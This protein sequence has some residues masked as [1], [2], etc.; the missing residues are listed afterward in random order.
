MGLD[1]AWNLYRFA[2]T[3]GQVYAGLRVHQATPVIEEAA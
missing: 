2:I 1:V 3:I